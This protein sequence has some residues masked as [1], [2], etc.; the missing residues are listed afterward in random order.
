MIWA[1]G[2]STA[3]GELGET[4]VVA[5]AGAVVDAEPP[6]VDVGVSLTVEDSVELAGAGVSAIELAI[7]TACTMTV[8]G[9]IGVLASTVFT[10]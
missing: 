1:I 4:P 8:V 6:G 9:E 10:G 2:D 3:L 5:D 7:G